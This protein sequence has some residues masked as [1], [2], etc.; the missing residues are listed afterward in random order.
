M[1][2]LSFEMV[3]L[4]DLAKRLDK[5]EARVEKRLIAQGSRAATS[6]LRKVLRKKLPRSDGIKLRKWRRDAQGSEGDG[7]KGE[8]EDV[9]IRDSIGIKVV[10]RSNSIVAR[11]GVVGLARAYAH[12]L[13]F[14][15]RF[16]TGNRIWTKTMRGESRKMLTIMADKIRAGLAKI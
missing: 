11:V 13:E 1:S 10:R 9:H 15:G 16:H 4:K 2:E 3:G 14:G 7:R 8:I 6:H 5:I 12:V